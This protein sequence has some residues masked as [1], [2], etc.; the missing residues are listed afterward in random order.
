M[1]VLKSEL[2]QLVTHEVGVKIDDVLEAARR[3]YVMLEGRQTAFQD[4][5]KAPEAL[6][7]SVDK[8]VEE[9]KYDLKTAEIVKRYLS[10]CSNALQNLSVQ[11]AN[12]RIAQGGKVQGFEQTIAVLKAILDAEKSKV[13]A[14]N[15]VAG[16]EDLNP[17]DRP[18]GVAPVS[19]KEQRLAEASDATDS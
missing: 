3:D 1:S 9:G 6:M 2:K 15:G 19:L 16:V 4:G 11:A 8:D 12:M 13:E 14:V 7:V 5:S 10:R 18:V 17:R